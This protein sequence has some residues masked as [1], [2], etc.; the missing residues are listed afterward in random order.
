MIGG[1]IV[2]GRL[3]CTFD[4]EISVRRRKGRQLA[5]AYVARRR[6]PDDGQQVLCRASLGEYVGD[7]RD[8]ILAVY[9]VARGEEVP[10]RAGRTGSPVIAWY[11]RA[12]SFR[13]ASGTGPTWNFGASPI[14]DRISARV[15]RL[16]VALSSGKEVLRAT[17]AMLRVRAWCPDCSS[18]IV[19]SLSWS[20]VSPVAKPKPPAF[21]P[22]VRVAEIVLGEL[23]PSAVEPG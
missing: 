13:S 8:G 22:R 20:H 7:K 9:A 15:H 17:R 12:R 16:A 19:A 1:P 4:L 21:G 23:K 3:R 10:H 14:R 5:I 18:A 6:D 11:C 2:T